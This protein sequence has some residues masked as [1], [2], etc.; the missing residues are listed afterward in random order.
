MGPAMGPA[1]REFVAC[2]HHSNMGWH[3][4]LDKAVAHSLVVPDQPQQGL[5][6]FCYAPGRCMHQHHTW[7]TDLQQQAASGYVKGCILMH[8]GQAG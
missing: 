3:T 1:G 8:V 7:H 6:A 2:T 4:Y 5:W